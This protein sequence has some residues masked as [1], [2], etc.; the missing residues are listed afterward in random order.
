M[1]SRPV[2]GYYAHHQGRGHLTRA[3]AVIAELD[4]DVTVLSS[5]AYDGPGGSV[6]LPLDEQTPSGR[7]DAGG[8]LHW[9]PLCS[10]GLR[11]RM[12]AISA[13]I[14]QA[15]PD[16]MVVDVS[17]EVALLA[18]LH[19]VPTVVVA[20]PGERADAPHQ[21]AYGAADAIIA[22][23]P[24][25]LYAPGWLTAH[26]DRTTYVGGVSQLDGRAAARPQI[27]DAQ[28]VVVLGS[29]GGDGITAD[30]VAAAAA[31]TPE[32]RWIP[33]GTADAPWVADPLDVLSGAGV[34]VTAA[35]QSAVADVAS[36][37]RPA[38]VICEDRPYGEQRATG[39]S[40]KAAALAT[41]LD[42]WPDPEQWPGLLCGV[43]RGEWARW[44]TRGAAQRT[45]AVIERVAG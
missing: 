29:R 20:M 2:I 43:P 40:L 28:T 22:C 38:I 7:S 44:E 15:R 12:A 13:W 37:G 34:V 14:E 33:V 18:R 26:D 41:V 36:V 5:A 39:A 32:W 24:R 35:G 1:T 16:A 17:V 30:A 4:A 6:T 25:A 10:S 27:G 42:H 21:L 9:A 3:G 19:G 11:S 8:V 45:A 23:W 31:A